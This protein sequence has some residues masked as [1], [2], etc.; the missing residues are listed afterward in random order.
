[1]I[2]C[3][4]RAPG[5][6]R[7]CRR[8]R[9]DAP[10]HVSSFAFGTGHINDP[11]ARGTRVR[12]RRAAGALRAQPP[13]PDRSPRQATRWCQNRRAGVFG[14]PAPGCRAGFET[15]SKIKA[16]WPPAVSGFACSGWLQSSPGDEAECE[17]NRYSRYGA[18]CACIASVGVRSRRMPGPIVVVSGDAADVLALGAARASPS[19]SRRP[20][21]PCCRAAPPRRS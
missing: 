2:G 21:S 17:L 6:R 9:R 16:G 1:M 13:A 7:G 15:M 19:R 8:A 3:V 10:L 14:S 4:R 11:R 18:Y 5:N 12:G 20:A